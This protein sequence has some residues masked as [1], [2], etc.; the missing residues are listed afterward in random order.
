VWRL[1]A[2]MTL[3]DA[4]LTRFGQWWKRAMRG[5]YAFALG[6]YLHGRSQE[7]HWIWESRRAWIW[8]FWLPLGCFISGLT[9]SPWGWA[10]FLAYPA[11]IVRQ[12]ARNEGPLK[13]RVTLAVFQLLMRFPE[14]IGQAKFLRDRLLGVRSQ[15]IEYK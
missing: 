9:F 1:K 2:E 5:G 12:A 7:R 15:L 3:H 14:A 8:G 10:T 13:Q 6:A 4:A 11:Q